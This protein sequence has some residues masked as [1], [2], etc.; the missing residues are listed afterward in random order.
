[1]LVNRMLFQPIH[2]LVLPKQLD[3]FGT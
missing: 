2:D 1:L 3:N